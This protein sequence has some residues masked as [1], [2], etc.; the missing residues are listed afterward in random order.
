M[1]SFHP[2]TQD[3]PVSGVPIVSADRQHLQA[4]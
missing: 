1:Q 4:A 3:A 2:N